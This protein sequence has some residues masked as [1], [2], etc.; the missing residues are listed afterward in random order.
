ML[1]VISRLIARNT[2]DP[3]LRNIILDITDDNTRRVLS[4]IE[5]EAYI[6]KEIS[7]IH[8]YA[9]FDLTEDGK[10]VFI[11]IYSNQIFEISPI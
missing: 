9:F 4:Y 7:N 8:N 1:L 11:N 5:D 6:L 3:R 2:L 10:Y